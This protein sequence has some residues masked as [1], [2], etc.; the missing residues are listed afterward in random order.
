MEEEEEGTEIRSRSIGFILYICH[1]SPT[2]TLWSPGTGFIS[3]SLSLLPPPCFSISISRSLCVSLFSTN[4]PSS[5]MQN[6]IRE[7]SRPDRDT[8]KSEFKS[9]PERIAR[10]PP[11]PLHDFL[12]LVSLFWAFI[13]SKTSRKISMY[14]VCVFEHLSKLILLNVNIQ[15]S[16]LLSQWRKNK[17]IIDLKKGAVITDYSKE[18]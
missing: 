14:F 15:I 6:G 5:Y 1:Y 4:I 13:E 2:G 18:G 12:W 9:D 7:R 8:G 11:S 3:F 17:I 16:N 10:P